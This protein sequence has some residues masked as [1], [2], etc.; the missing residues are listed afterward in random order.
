MEMRLLT[1]LLGALTIATSVAAQSISLHIEPA[2]GQ[3]QFRI[4]EEIGLKLAFEMMNDTDAPPAGQPGWMIMLNGHDRSVLGFGRDRFVVTP[5]AGTR[6][7]WSYRLH[8]G[9]AYSGPGG[10]RLSDKPLVLNID[11]NQWARFERPGHYTVHA[12]SH[13]TGPQRQDVEVESNQIGIDIV[14]ADPQWQQ[15]ELATDLAILNSTLSKIDSASFESRMNAARR[16]TYLDTPAAVREMVRWLGIADIQTAQILQDGLRSSQHGPETVAAMKELLRSPSEPVP[17][18]FLRTLAALDKA[19][20]EPQNALAEV[21]EQKQGSAKAI[22]IKTLL[23]SMSAESVPATLRSEIAALFPQLPASQQSELL[24]YQWKK[25]DAPDMIPVLRQIY[26][27][28]P[29][30]RYPED[31]LL[32]S[33]VERLYELDTSR[34][35]TLLLEEMTRPDPRLLYRTLAM[36][37]DATLP[38]LD[39]TLLDHL[40]HNGGRPAEELIARYSTKS[41]LG[42]VKDF[43][44]KRDAEMRSRV[45]TNPNIAAPACEP[46]LVAYFLRIDPA[47]GE[48]VLRQ[49]LAERGYTMGR[50]WLGIIGQTAVYNSGPVWERVAIDALQDPAVPVKIDAVK[51][52]AQYG[53]PTAKPAIFEAFRYWHEWWE[54][55]GEQNE[56]SRRLEQ[57]FVE[58][59]TRPKNWTPAD[60]D[61]ATIRDLCLTAGCKSQ[62]PQHQN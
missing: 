20:K 7:P 35:R 30:S 53:S 22:S 55:R 58:A 54:N 49:S 60:A 21:V 17:P 34:T 33:A 27:T 47:W 28:A 45:T 51:S 37:P 25:I 32:A 38:E 3:S 56:E 18:V 36:L 39:A 9:I 50:C 11:L 1:M 31:P 43:Y 16:L 61:L 13:A 8:E 5:E 12:L 40:Q 14:A 2:L 15:Q 44:A 52:L 23:D 24:D 41:I 6:D 42:P 57:A 62:V 46:P 4:G 26:E 29:Q 48:T 59:T 19:I 10:S